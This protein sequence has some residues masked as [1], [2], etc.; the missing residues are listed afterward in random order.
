MRS[1]FIYPLDLVK[2]FLQTQASC[3][4]NTP[5]Q[6]VI[7][8]TLSKELNGFMRQDFLHRSHYTFFPLYHVY[9]RSFNDML[10]RNFPRLVFPSHH[11]GSVN[12]WTSPN[13]PLQSWDHLCHVLF[14]EHLLSGRL[15]TAASGSF[16]ALG[17]YNTVLLINYCLFYWSVLN[18]SLLNLSYS[19]FLLTR[20]AHAM[21]ISLKC[22]SVFRAHLTFPFLKAPWALSITYQAAGFH[23]VWGRS[24]G[25]FYSFN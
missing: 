4:T 25:F 24:E 1:L 20:K 19:Y 17:K 7:T 16:T 12:L 13:F 5:P 15:C 14:P 2:T 18:L 9:P 3:S 21:G 8:L 11:Y 6:L 23:C 10:H 22:Y